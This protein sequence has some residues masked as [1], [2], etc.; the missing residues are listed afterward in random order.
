[1]RDPMMEMTGLTENNFRK[2]IKVGEIG[3]KNKEKDFLPLALVRIPI[4]YAIK[5]ITGERMEDGKRHRI[6]TSFP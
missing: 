3:A 1:M 4:L 6:T 2:K 5:G